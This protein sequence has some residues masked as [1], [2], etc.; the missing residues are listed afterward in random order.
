MNKTVHEEKAREAVDM[1]ELVDL[2]SSTVQLG[3]H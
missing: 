2:D 3:T 1:I